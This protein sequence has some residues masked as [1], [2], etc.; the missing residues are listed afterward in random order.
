V[1]ITRVALP[2]AKP[3]VDQRAGLPVLSPEETRAEIEKWRVA[4]QALRDAH[5]MPPLCEYPKCRDKWTIMF[6]LD[7]LSL[8]RQ[9]LFP[10]KNPSFDAVL[11]CDKHHKLLQ[12]KD[13]IKVGYRMV[14]GQTKAYI[15]EEYF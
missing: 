12:K 3:K 10:D 1:K 14:D 7:Q 6:P 2:S 9:K 13:G 11:A 5:M 4:I 15:Q 8:G